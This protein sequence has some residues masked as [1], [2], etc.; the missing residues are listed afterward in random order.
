MCGFGWV[1][2][3]AHLVNT[4]KPLE[5]NEFITHQRL[6]WGFPLKRQISLFFVVVDDIQSSGAVQFPQ[7]ASVHARRILNSHEWKGILGE[8]TPH[9][10]TWRPPVCLDA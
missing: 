6:E 3:L 2:Y 9:L 10:C 8:P 4:S 5:S 7:I 1:V